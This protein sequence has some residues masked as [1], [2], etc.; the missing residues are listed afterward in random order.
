MLQYYRKRSPVRHI[1]MYDETNRDF[2]YSSDR[3]NNNYYLPIVF[4]PKFT[5]DRLNAMGRC[6]K[7]EFKKLGARGILNSHK[8]DEDLNKP[9]IL[10][11]SKL[12]GSEESMLIETLNKR[13]LRG[14]RNSNYK[15]EPIQ[16]YLA[17]S[18]DEAVYRQTLVDK[19]I[20]RLS[21]EPAVVNYYSIEKDSDYIY[22]IM[23]T[24]SFYNFEDMYMKLSKELC[25]MMLGLIDDS[26]VFQ[27]V[28]FD[29]L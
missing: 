1:P 23:N 24:N 13:M 5:V 15:L 9:A 19:L 3:D 29:T 14:I 18:L 20:P 12:L 28:F 27:S 6:Y 10:A 16:K 4:V 7:E 26:F 25:E 2:N 22:I 17:Y 21:V 11:F 8:Y